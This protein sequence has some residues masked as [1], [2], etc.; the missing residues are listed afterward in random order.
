MIQC[1]ESGRTHST[2]T[3]EMNKDDTDWTEISLYLKLFAVKFVINLK[4]LQALILKETTRSK[5]PYLK[6]YQPNDA[7]GIPDSSGMSH[8]PA[9]PLCSCLLRTCVC[10]W[11][12]LPK[13]LSSQS[14]EHERLQLFEEQRY[15]ATNWLITG[16]SWVPVCSISLYAMSY[17]FQS[18][19]TLHWA[20]PVMLTIRSMF[21]ISSP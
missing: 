5:T 15:S 3:S 1:V 13:N 12:D 21:H 18:F 2:F 17:A 8:C 10:R 9:V 20:F 7:N 4:L 11:N 6:N 16:R 14:S 19:F